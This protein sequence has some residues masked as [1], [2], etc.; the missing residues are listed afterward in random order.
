MNSTDRNSA[1]RV[2]FLQDLG[3]DCKDDSKAFLGA[4]CYD[5]SAIDLTVKN[6]L[7]RIDLESFNSGFKA[8]F[9]NAQQKMREALGIED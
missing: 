7:I 2:K 1:K 3:F 9:K 6:V 4:S 5:F 8:G